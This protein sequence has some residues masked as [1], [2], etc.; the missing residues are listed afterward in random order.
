MRIPMKKSLIQKYMLYHTNMIHTSLI[1]LACVFFFCTCSEPK[2]EFM[3]TSGDLLFQVNEKNDFTNAIVNTTKMGQ[4]ISFSH[5]G[6]LII[7]K[8]KYYV[9][10][11]NPNNGVQLMQLETFLKES[12]HTKKGEPMVVVKR[13]INSTY[14]KLA[15]ERAKKYIGDPYDYSFLP[16]NEAMYCSELVYESYL[17]K[18]DKP[19]FTAHPMSF[20]DS[21]GKIS[22]LWIEFF[23][24]LNIPIPIGEPGTNPNDM[25]QDKVLKEVYRYFSI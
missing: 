22:P 18:N 12:A 5:V 24:N 2:N 21:T 8:G 6:I 7:E 1:V 4:H 3:L 11:A 15:A 25:A 10:D 14:A 19:L 20:S 16:N 9:I 13:L 23:S 17:D